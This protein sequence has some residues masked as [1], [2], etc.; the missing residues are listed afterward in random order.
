MWQI[1]S[2][3]SEQFF[4]PVVGIFWF[5]PILKPTSWKIHDWRAH[6][7]KWIYSLRLGK[8]TT[9]YYSFSER[10][11]DTNV[12]VIYELQKNHWTVSKA[13]EALIENNTKAVP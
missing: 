11:E 9:F 1:N 4:F 13:T 3:S 6:V 7:T 5:F 10:S 2:L 8:I 12:N